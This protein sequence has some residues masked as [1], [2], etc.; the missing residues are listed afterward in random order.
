MKS[1]ILTLS[2]IFLA[3]GI[4]CIALE[5][6]FYQYVDEN[7]VLHESFFMPLGAIFV[8]LGIV[9]LTYSMLKFIWTLIK[10]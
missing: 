3:V 8:M 6:Y 5:N 10:K 9:G 7:G 4:I 2:V 1:K